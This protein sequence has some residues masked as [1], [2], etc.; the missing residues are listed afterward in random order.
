MTVDNLTVEW[1]RK[2]LSDLE[3]S[4]KEIQEKRN[5]LT[6]SASPTTT[7][8]ND[9]PNGK[10]QTNESSNNGVIA[11]RLINGV[12]SSK[13]E[14]NLLKCQERKM[15]KQTELIKIAL[16]ELGCEEAPSGCDLSIDNQPTFITNSSEQVGFLSSCQNDLSVIL[17]GFI[18]EPVFLLG[19]FW[20]LVAL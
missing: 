14:I 16:N 20:W 13:K 19:G 17:F 2:K 7:T 12:D 8:N 9:Q 6:S 11:T 10:I 18:N 3:S 5:T 1:L 15:L 4:I